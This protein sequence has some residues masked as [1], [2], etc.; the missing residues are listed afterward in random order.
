MDR[1]FM[2]VSTT[3]RLT[4]LARREIERL[5]IFSSLRVRKRRQAFRRQG[6]LAARVVPTCIGIRLLV[7]AEPDID[8]LAGEVAAYAD[9]ER[10]PGGLGLLRRRNADARRPR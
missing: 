8:G 1:G 4:R 5:L 6:H 7:E 3:D 2:M 9:R 10:D